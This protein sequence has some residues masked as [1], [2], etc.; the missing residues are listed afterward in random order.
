MRGL[1]GQ[2]DTS[3]RPRLEACSTPAPGTGGCETAR[4][5][6]A[7]LGAPPLSP[8]VP[9]RITPGVSPSKKADIPTLR[10]TGHFYFALTDRVRAPTLRTTRPP[11]DR[12]IVPTWVF[13]MVCRQDDAGATAADHFKPGDA[14]IWLGHCAAVRFEGN[15]IVEP[16][17]CFGRV[18]EVSST[19]QDVAGLED[20]VRR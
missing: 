18:F 20:G 14:L 9:L 4:H 5:G 17:A 6:V 19:A 16:G 8:G 3:N 12:D 10:E 1:L 13:D 2:E 15:T 11:H 7:S